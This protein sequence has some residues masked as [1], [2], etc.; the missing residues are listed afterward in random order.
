MD[1]MKTNIRV[2]GECLVDVQECRG[3]EWTDGQFVPGHFDKEKGVR[4]NYKS[5]NRS[6]TGIITGGK[7]RIKS[8]T[9]K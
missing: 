7:T 1:G 5:K 2:S 8:R 6:G 3:A 4:Q 9:R